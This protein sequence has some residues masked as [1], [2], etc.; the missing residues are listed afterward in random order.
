MRIAYAHTDEE[1]LAAFETV[2][3]LR[4]HLSD[5]ALYLKQIREMQQEGYRLLYL[6]VQEGGEE[7]VAAIA[8]FRPMHKLHTG[9]GY[10][11]DDLSTL[12]A[13]RGKGYG[14]QLLDYI[15]QLAK[16]EGKTVVE[17]DSGYHRLDAHRLY[18][19]RRYVLASHHF[20]HKIS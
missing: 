16:E 12:P 17:L 4:P 6:S 1:I 3:A 15:H 7:V 14:G 9:K 20:S 10:Y 2:Q 19:N 13:L 8:G 18:L 11:I 5:P